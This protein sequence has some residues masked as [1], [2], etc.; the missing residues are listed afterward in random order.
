MSKYS[1]LK[2]IE[3]KV[4][5]SERLSFEDGI[6]LYNSDEIFTIGRL[7]NIIRERK[8]GNKVYFITNLHINYTNICVNRCDFCAFSRDHDDKDAY[9]LTPE[10]IVNIAKE[11]LPNGATEIHIV[12]GLH[13]DLKIEYY[14]EFLSKLK[15]LYPH[16]HLQAL[17]AVEIEHI[18]SVSGLTVKETLIRLKDAGLGSLPGGGAE[19][20]SDRI[21]KKLCPKKI[22]GSQWL[23]VLRT[24]HNLGIRSNATMLYGHIETVEERLDHLIQLRNLQD[25]TKGFMSFIPLSFHPEN[26]K[27]KHL[28]N[29]GGLLD[30]KTIAI[31]RLILDNFDHI[32]SFWIMLGLKLAQLSLSFGAD[33][34]DGTVVEEQITHS[35]GA[36]TPQTVTRS[37]LID[38]I[39]EAGRM[40]T[41][42]DTLY[43]NI[44]Q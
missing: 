36:K 37:E 25:E 8:N 43:N 29:P 31:S 16:I 35:A 10:Q 26:T 7:A 12:G 9:T 11:K 33:D 14:L 6:S 32:K 22:S 39:Q 17:T 38:L 3:K 18:A 2:Q 27:L 41:E 40:P 4:L 23:N 20:F 44:K 15:N 1:D 42:R 21:R 28:N 19:I 24:A 34:I 30:L 5:N 13:P